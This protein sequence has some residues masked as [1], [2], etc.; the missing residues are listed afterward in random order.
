MI[1]AV[2]DAGKYAL[3]RFATVLPYILAV[4]EP[5]CR[6]P[7]TTG[8]DTLVDAVIELILFEVEVLPIEL[9]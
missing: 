6:I 3:F 5:A 9:L 4:P 1:S 8:T 2:A 7:V